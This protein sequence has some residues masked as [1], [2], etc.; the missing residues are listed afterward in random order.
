MRRNVHLLRCRIAGFYD[1]WVIWFIRNGLFHCMLFDNLVKRGGLAFRWFKFLNAMTFS[2]PRSAICHKITIFSSFLFGFSC[3]QN[4]TVN[5]IRYSWWNVWVTS[6][7]TE[8]GQEKTHYFDSHPAPPSASLRFSVARGKMSLRPSFSELGFDVPAQRRD[9]GPLTRV[10]VRI[11][12]KKK[13]KVFC[14]IGGVDIL[15]M[16][17][18]ANVGHFSF[19]PE[20]RKARTYIHLPSIISLSYQGREGVEEKGRLRCSICGCCICR[21]EVGSRMTTHLH[22]W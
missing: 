5:R 17:R 18:E 13:K 22:P 6:D 12:L 16:I 1:G 14:Q 9:T 15:G 2:S 21:L 11:W 20:S 8:R 10:H 4:R 7:K 3:V 19:C